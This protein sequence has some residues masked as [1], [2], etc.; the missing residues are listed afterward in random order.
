M[1]TSF[2]AARRRL[3]AR[4][5]AALV[6]APAGA[7]LL[8]FSASASA[9]AAAG[10]PVW[11][12]VSGPLTGPNAQ[13]GAQ[14]QAGFDL[15]LDQINAEGG[16]NGHPLRYV[17]EDSQSDPRQAVT[18]AQK[19]VA[20]SRI[21]IELG[22]FSSPASMAASPIYQ[23]AGLVQLGF[24]NSHP[25]FTKGGDYIWSPSVSQ[26]D[27]QPLIAD[28][29]VKQGFKRV[30]V[31]YQN[32]DWGRA[33][34]D[35]FV[36]ATNARGA[37]VVDA[38][39]YQPTDK[40]FRATL[41]RVRDTHPDALVLIAYYADGAQIVRQARESGIGLPVVAASSVYSPKFL[42]LGGDAVNG[43]TT[44]TSFF[45]GDPRPEVQRFVQ[46]FKAKYHREPDAFNAFAYD[47]VII[48]AN[49]LRTGGTTRQGVHDAL[50]KLHDVPSVVFGKATFDPRTRRI[51]GV[52]SIDLVVHDGQWTLLPAQQTVAAKQ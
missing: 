19:F 29:A 49:A 42:E 21:L 8:A 40:D 12:G 26:T 28:L 18:I 31:L 6:L 38:D 3:L 32:T 7:S 35:V 10:E 39:G 17:F 4:L 11:F 30:A 20:D 16:I 44:N 51:D 9:A 37:Q 36:K 15:A 23:R 34:K 47:A 22:D 50:P 43:V 45:P 13:Y 46:G 27:A 52:K 24:T 1:K 41:V 48:A 2:R 25:D 33:S 5:A 14:W